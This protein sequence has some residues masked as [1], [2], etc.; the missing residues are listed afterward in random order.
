VFYSPYPANPKS[1][2]AKKVLVEEKT[3]NRNEV[4]MVE[5]VLPIS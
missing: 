3:D 2:I 1:K 4:A 5:E